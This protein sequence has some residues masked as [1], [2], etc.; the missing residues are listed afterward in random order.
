MLNNKILIIISALTI[1]ILISIC[2]CFSGKRE[3]ILDNAAIKNILTR[4]S[5]RKY[6]R[7]LVEKEK[8]E[9]LL[10]AAMSAPSAANEQPWD[11]IVVTDK[12]TI[13]KVCQ[14]S[15]YTT[16][17]KRARLCIIVCGNLQKEREKF[18][19]HWVLGCSAATENILLAANA[20]GLGAVWIGLY[21]VQDKMES[22]STTF[23]LPEHIKPM[24][25]ISI[26]YP[27]EKKDPADR[28]IDTNVHWEKW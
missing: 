20:I 27:A 19:G 22:I 5:I 25:V 1:G 6:T 8:I 7:R 9:I 17:L 12:K 15:P 24:A 28:F 11:F 18:R 14:A 21:P 10:K 26:G 16:P 23:S 2:T 3:N 4:R 13:S